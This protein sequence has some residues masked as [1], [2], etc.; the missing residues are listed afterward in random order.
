MLEAAHELGIVQ[1]AGDRPRS[2]LVTGFPISIAEDDSKFQVRSQKRSRVP[3]IQQRRERRPSAGDARRSP[4]N[5]P[6]DSCE[7]LDRI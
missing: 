4:F 1:T 2:D 6:R 7:R 5:S 3:H